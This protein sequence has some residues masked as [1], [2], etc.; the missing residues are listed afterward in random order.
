M[1]TPYAAGVAA[2]IKVKNPSFT[3]AQVKT[4]MQAKG[5]SQS[6]ACDGASEGG[7]VQGAN[8]KGSERLLWA[9]AY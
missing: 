2:L 8:A 7:L 3:P 1:A 4:D 5:L 9:E 6:L